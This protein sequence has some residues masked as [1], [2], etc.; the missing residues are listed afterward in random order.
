MSAL[1]ASQLEAM[2]VAPILELPRHNAAASREADL[3][4]CELARELH[5]QV[6]QSLTGLLMQTQVFAREQQRH[7]DVVDEL[8]FVQT[9]VREVLNNVRQILAD[10]RGQP[11]LSAGLVPAIR[12]ELLR[13]FQNR[14]GTKSTL[15]V[16]PSWPAALPPETGIQIYRIIQE[17]LVNSH[18]HG[19]AT[20]V[21]VALKGWSDERLVVTIRDDGRGIA[22]LDD[23]KPIGMGILGMRERAALL[24]GVLTIR[25]RPLAGTT[26]TASFSKEALSWLPKH[27][28]PAS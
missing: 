1:P 20:K 17:A 8:N 11:G 16:S 9:S 28:L 4:K 18:K 19:G 14:T 27:T 3:I 26:V 5:D 25:S 6:A 21:H 23:E 22:W 24:G 13:G 10:L 7:Q 2:T 12:D 15:W